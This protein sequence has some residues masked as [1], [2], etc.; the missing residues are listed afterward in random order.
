MKYYSD[1]ESSAGMNIGI[2]LAPVKSIIGRAVWFGA[3][4]REAVR[5]IKLGSEKALFDTLF[6]SGTAPDFDVTKTLAATS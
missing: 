5:M 2:E 6:N 1:W 3:A 4:L